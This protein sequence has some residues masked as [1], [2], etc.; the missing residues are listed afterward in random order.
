MHL[1]L[2]VFVLVNVNGLRRAAYVS[3]RKF[4][5]VD[6]PLTKGKP[7]LH[8]FLQLVVVLWKSCNDEIIH[9]HQNL[10]QKTASLGLKDGV[11][12]RLFSYN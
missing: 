9:L 1:F 4:G 12:C 6:L 8:L 3:A 11:Q 10:T 7:I 5:L 2:N